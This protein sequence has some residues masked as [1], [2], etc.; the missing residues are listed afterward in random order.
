MGLGAVAILVML[1]GMSMFRSA[2][3]I[4][5]GEMAGVAAEAL[6]FVINVGL[7]VVGNHWAWVGWQ[8]AALSKVAFWPSGAA[9]DR[10]ALMPRGYITVV[11]LTAAL[12]NGVVYALF[13][14]LR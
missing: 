5:E 6:M 1:A 2:Q 13:Q 9:A 10:V 11:M 8:A 3:F 12:L 7:L 4:E 14:W